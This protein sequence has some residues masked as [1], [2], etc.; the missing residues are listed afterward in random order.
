MGRSSRPGGNHV[1]PHHS[2]P[3]C[4]VAISC[5]TASTSF[6]NVWRCGRL[7]LQQFV[8]GGEVSS[9]GNAPSVLEFG[10]PS[11]MTTAPA[12]T[13]RLLYMAIHVR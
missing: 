1:I 6:A 9:M 3:S 10:T 5:F 13:T 4:R 8:S 2:A 12:A 11:A 7:I